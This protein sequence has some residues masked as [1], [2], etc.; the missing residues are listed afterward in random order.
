MKRFLFPITLLASLLML[1]LTLDSCDDDDQRH[2]RS[3]L[4]GEWISQDD[5][6]DIFILD[7]YDDGT[8]S[9]E[10]RIYESSL[11]DNYNSYH[12]SFDWDADRRYIYVS[13]YSDLAQ[14]SWPYYFSGNYLYIDG[15]PFNYNIGWSKRYDRRAFKPIEMNNN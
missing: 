7:F 11:S 2:I 5:P 1:T 6:N 12:E 10:E 4:V 15:I 3:R 8:G 13:Y 14:D 9:R